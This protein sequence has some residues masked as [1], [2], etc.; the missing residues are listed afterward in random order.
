MDQTSG[1]VLER[2]VMEVVL[3]SNP[4]TAEEEK[5]WQILR[6]NTDLIMSRWSEFCPQ[7]GV[8]V[9]TLPP[10]VYH[11]SAS[12]PLVS[13]QF[14][15]LNDNFILGGVLF[16]STPNIC[17]LP[18][19]WSDGLEKKRPV[20]DNI[21]TEPAVP[22][23]VQVRTNERHSFLYLPAV[24]NDRTR[25]SPVALVNF[26]VRDRTETQV[27]RR[28]RGRTNTHSQ[29]HHGNNCQKELLQFRVSGCTGG[30][31]QEV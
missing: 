9:Q 1:Q 26:P 18:P 2:S 14:G 7:V 11:N 8:G 10:P 28:H 3:C 16:F 19:R 12:H 13:G 30:E 15:K 17:R 27:Q 21:Q 20:I 24:D 31:T 23:S 22:V 5:L 4:I 6:L 29:W 25:A